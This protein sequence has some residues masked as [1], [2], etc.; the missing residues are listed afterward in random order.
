[1]QSL[2][3]VASSGW[4]IRRSRLS[5]HML[6]VIFGEVTFPPITRVGCSHLARHAQLMY[7]AE[8]I[9]AGDLHWSELV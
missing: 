7:R 5:V 8:G 3:F 6:S 4:Y 9:I 2:L 1:M